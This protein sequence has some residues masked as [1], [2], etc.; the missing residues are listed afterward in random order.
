MGQRLRICL[1]AGLASVAFS[2]CHVPAIAWI[3]RPHT[4]TVHTNIATV[5][6]NCRTAVLDMTGFEDTDFGT[7]G[8]GAVPPMA[9]HLANGRFHQEITGIDDGNPQSWSLIV[10][11]AAGAELIRRGGEIAC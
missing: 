9:L 4:A 8:Y 10:Y 11:S 1:T 3:G 5:D 6:V 2:A 7:F